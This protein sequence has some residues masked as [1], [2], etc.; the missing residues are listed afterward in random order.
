MQ[1]VLHAGAHFTDDDKLLKSLGKNREFLAGRGVSVPKPRS[2]RNALRSVLHDNLISADTRTDI[3]DE[4]KDP[5]A[6]EPDRIIFSNSNFFCVPRLAVRDNLYYPQS[7]ERLQD[8]CSIFSSD[9]VEIFFAIRNPA[10]LLPALLDGSPYDRIEDVIGDTAP[11]ALRWTELIE[12]MRRELP[13]A[14]LTVWCNEDTPLIWEQ[15]LRELSGVEPTQALDGGTDL[16]QEIMTA[17]G[18]RRFDSYVNAHPNMTEMQKRRVMAA[19]LDKFAIDEELEQELDIPGWTEDVIDALTEIYD[20][21]VYDIS[22]LPGV[23]FISP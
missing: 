22:R 11:T 1:I 5:S 12:R 15:L 7:E 20:E 9:E 2:Y 21:D 14:A 16:L 19:F 6:Q 23:T 17:E 8:F 3:L 18:I 10:T 13:N 4:L